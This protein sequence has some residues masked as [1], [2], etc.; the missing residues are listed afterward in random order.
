MGLFR[1]ESVVLNYSNLQAAKEW[2]ITAFDCKPMKVPA[3]WDDP[4]PSDIALA[5]PGDSAP[6]ILLNAQA[7]VEHQQ[8]FER[9][10]PTVPIIFCDKLKKAHEQLSSRGIVAGAIQDDGETQFFEIRDIEEHIIEIC[11]EP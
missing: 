10:T 1:T 11:K 7:E 2:W 3:D 5:L 8:Q 4:L 9:S 6:T